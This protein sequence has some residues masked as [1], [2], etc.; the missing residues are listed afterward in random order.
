LSRAG[1]DLL[2]RQGAAFRTPCMYAPESHGKYER[3][4]KS[5]RCL[6][7]CILHAKYRLGRRLL[8]SGTDWI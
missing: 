4:G 7:F 1:T 2:A 8:P 3:N 6:Y 5:M